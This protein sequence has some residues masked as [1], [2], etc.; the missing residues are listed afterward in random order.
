MRTNSPFTSR[1]HTIQAPKCTE[2]A[3]IRHLGKYQQKLGFN[4]D[5]MGHDVSH[6]H[7]K[8]HQLSLLIAPYGPHGVSK[9]S[10]TQEGKGIRTACEPRAKLRNEGCFEGNLASHSYLGVT[11]AFHIKISCV[12]VCACV[13]LFADKSVRSQNSKR[14]SR[15]PEIIGFGNV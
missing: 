12:C 14:S 15:K 7:T 2:L 11:Q 1:P 10:L 9:P 5:G 3:A 8:V 6:T 13:R 4:K